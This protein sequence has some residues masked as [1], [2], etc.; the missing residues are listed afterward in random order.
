[1]SI[2]NEEK[3]SVSVQILLLCSGS[4]AEGCLLAVEFQSERAVRTVP[5]RRKV[6]CKLSR[7]KQTNFIGNY[8]Y[9][10]DPELSLESEASLLLLAAPLS[11]LS[12]CRI[13][14]PLFV[15]RRPAPRELDLR[16][17]EG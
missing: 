11:D 7:G 15:R 10:S 12:L 4:G 17:I 9:H 1:M 16:A 8:G 14:R 2:L 5:K 6:L 13:F 3:L